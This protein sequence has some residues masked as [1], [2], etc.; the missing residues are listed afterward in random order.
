M[1]KP[2]VARSK[3]QTLGVEGKTFVLHL[4]GGMEPQSKQER[5]EAQQEVESLSMRY[6]VREVHTH[7]VPMLDISDVS[8]RIAD[9]LK[10]IM[11]G[12]DPAHK[13]PSLA[14]CLEALYLAQWEL[15][16]AIK[17]VEKQLKAEGID[18]KRLPFSQDSPPPSLQEIGF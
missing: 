5:M 12:A 6:P 11:P 3:P 7:G 9:A 16:D 18:I 4:F 10:A 15:F 8:I 2:M 1:S 14:E 17:V 13:Q